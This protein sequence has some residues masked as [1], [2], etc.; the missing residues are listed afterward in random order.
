MR[1]HDRPWV[2]NDA[3]GGERSGRLADRLTRLPAG[4]PSAD[5]ADADSPEPDDHAPDDIEP[6]PV[7]PGDQVD[8]PSGG[9]RRRSAEPVT[10]DALGGK[11]KDHSP[12]RPWFSADGASD[13]WFA[14][15]PMDEP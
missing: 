10:W 7:G 2:E 6:G 13:P 8:G 14:E 4:H 9:F 5:V 1:A 11:D 12:Y 3:D 15:P